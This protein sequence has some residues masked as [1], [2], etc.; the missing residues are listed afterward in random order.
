MT[1]KEFDIF[2]RDISIV[3]DRLP[4]DTS[5]EEKMNILRPIFGEVKIMTM[6]IEPDELLDQIAESIKKTRQ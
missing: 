3:L 1:K 4:E 2:K 5:N 6:D